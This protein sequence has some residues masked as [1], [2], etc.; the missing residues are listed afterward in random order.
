MY[1]HSRKVLS[2]RL[3]NTPDVDFCV[4]ALEEALA[5]YGTPD[6]LNSDQGSQFASY[7]FTQVLK[8]ARVKISMD[9]R[10]RCMDNVMIEPL[11]LPE[12]RMRLSECF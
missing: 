1:W 4:A 2:W 3:S 5:K 11:A 12:I 6:I 7:P 10:G 8:D 9:G